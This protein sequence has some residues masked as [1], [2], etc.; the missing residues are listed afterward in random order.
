MAEAFEFTVYK[1]Y[2]IQLAKRMGRPFC[3]PKEY[4][5][6][7]ER[8][9]YKLFMFLSDKLKNNGIYSEKQIN[10]FFECAGEITLEYYVVDFLK[11]FDRIIELFKNKKEIT[12]DERLL[13]I[14]KSFDYLKEYCLLN[15][16][17]DLNELCV[18]NPPIILKLWKNN[19]IMAEVLAVTFDC[20]SIKKKTWYRIYCGNLQ[21]NIN[22][23][24]GDHGLSSILNN[25]V[26][27]IK[28]EIKNST[29]RI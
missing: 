9:D 21:Q 5:A 28:N 29:C 15:N 11:D 10:K 14:K 8:N 20:E 2:L 16:V 23:I 4:K 17:K 18:G 24:R 13:K 1:I 25:E 22:K 12:Q 3:V 6:L 19:K 7:M 27:N 26:L